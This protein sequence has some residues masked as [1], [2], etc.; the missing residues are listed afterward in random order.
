M[1]PLLGAMLCLCTMGWELHAQLLPTRCQ[2]YPLSMLYQ[3]EHFQTL[4][5]VPWG[6]LHP[7]ESLLGSRIPI[8]HSVSRASP[9]RELSHSS[10][11]SGL[12]VL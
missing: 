3:P 8:C 11:L 7:L 6:G 5:S 1:T 12:S 4:P 9:P 2:Q 10:A